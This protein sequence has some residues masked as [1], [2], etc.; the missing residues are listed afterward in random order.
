MYYLLVQGCQPASAAL[1][2]QGY[3]ATT[4]GNAA[5]APGLAPQLLRYRLQ[6]VGQNQH[7]DDVYDVYDVYDVL[8]I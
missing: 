3:G 1:D 6:H 7:A 4:P 5:T 2:P 8:R